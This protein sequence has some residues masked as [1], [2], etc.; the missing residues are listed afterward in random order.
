M[1]LHTQDHVRLIILMITNTCYPYLQCLES[2]QNH[3]DPIILF[4]DG[5]SR[6]VPKITTFEHVLDFIFDLSIVLG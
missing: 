3:L 5:F 1:S 6:T 2:L 4:L